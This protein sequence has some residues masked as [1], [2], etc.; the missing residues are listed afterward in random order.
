[1][2]PSFYLGQQ[3]FLVSVDCIILGFKN[4]KLYLLLT[5][6]R[7]EPQK[8]QNSL[9]GGFIRSDENL[10]DTVSRTVYEYTGITDMFMEQVGT[11]GE[12][13]RDEGERVISIAYYALINIESYDD[14]LSKIH[15]TRWVELDKVGELIFDHNKILN[16]AINALRK[17]ALT[18]PIG[19]NLLPEKFTLPQLQ[20]LY[21]AIYD[22][23]YD[24]RNFRKKISEMDILVKLDEKDK[25]AS[26]KGAYYYHFN[27]EKYD[28]LLEKGFYMSF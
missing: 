7:F 4:N 6:R 26:K 15:N 27:K 16:D 25:S 19:F 1:M 21:E 24:K 13:G 2:T 9:M 17:K 22:I 10:T 28:Q 3:K 12:I 23:T 11:Y 20:A 8:G 5:K 18:R 14:E